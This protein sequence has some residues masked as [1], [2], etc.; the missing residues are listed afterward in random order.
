VKAH[1]PGDTITLRVLRR[2][3]VTDVTVQ[4]SAWPDAAADQFAMDEFRRARE[5]AA[6]AYFKQVF[7]PLFDSGA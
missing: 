3:K 4:L 1:D 6:E 7:A 2:G 5:A